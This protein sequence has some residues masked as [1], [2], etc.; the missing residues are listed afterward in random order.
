MPVP[1]RLETGRINRRESIRLESRV[2]ATQ[3][4]CAALRQFMVDAHG[5]AEIGGID[6][7]AR[8]F[9]VEVDLQVVGAQQQVAALRQ[10]EARRGR[11]VRQLPAVADGH[12]S[13]VTARR[14]AEAAARNTGVG[15]IRANDR[16]LGVGP[17][18]ANRRFQAAVRIIEVE[19]RIGRVVADT[20]AAATAAGKLRGVHAGRKSE[21]IDLPGISKLELRIAKTT[22]HGILGACEVEVVVAVGLATQF[23]A[24]IELPVAAPARLCGQ[25]QG[26]AEAARDRGGSH[27]E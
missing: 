4:Q 6:V 10:I 17:E 15:T 23:D 9:P 27:P 19:R 13:G 25:C 22:L 24:R 16:L 21:I 12:V 18:N 7:G 26:D 5:T 2:A 8:N 11:H 3:D 20:T 1:L 14:I